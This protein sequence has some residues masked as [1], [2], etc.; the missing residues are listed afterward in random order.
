MKQILSISL[1]FS[2]ML[3]LWSLTVS[4][5]NQRGSMDNGSKNGYVIERDD[6]IAQKQNGPHDGGGT[7]TGY[8]FF[9][10]VGAMDY[11]FRK[12]ALHPG[13]GI[14]YHEQKKDEIYYVLSGKGELTMNGK[15][16]IVGP[17]TA[18]LTRSGSAHGLKQLGEEDLV[19]FIIYSK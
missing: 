10:S 14:G 9:S 3:V 1:C 4:G 12:R 8:S 18:I 7:T 13:S 16:S 6:Q 11:V 19:I 5:Q 15:K 17:G 2:T